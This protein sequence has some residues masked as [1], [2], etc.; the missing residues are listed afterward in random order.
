VKYFVTGA[1]GFIGRQVAQQLLAAGHEVVAFGRRP[2]AG[3]ESP[4]LQFAQGDVTDAAAL[5]TS[6]AGSDGLFHLA[7]WYKL[8][9]RNPSEGYRINVEGTRCVLEAMRD[10]GVPKGVYTSTL[11]VFSDTQG[12]LPDETYRYT[13]PHLTEYDRTKWLAHYEVAEPLIQAGLPLV[14]VQPGVVYGPGDKSP[15]NDMFQQFL[16]R[17]L[18]AVPL[19]T[20]YCWGHVED[21]A[22]GHLLAMERGR[23]GESYILAGPRHTIV[24]TLEIASRISGVPLTRRRLSP[25]FLR[26]LAWLMRGVGRVLPVPTSLHYESLIAI[27]GTTYLGDN[28][29]ARTELGFD[30]RPLEAGLP[31]ILPTAKSKSAGTR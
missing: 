22:H 10:T 23:I 12:Q 31:T 2:P 16:L 25:V 29:K 13:G 11:A 8:G 19:Q 17:K 14:I 30:P 4:Q 15:V 21:T 7:G 26:R 27:A 3:L 28:R 18:W 6:M 1:T 9:A 24:E 20:E 5:R